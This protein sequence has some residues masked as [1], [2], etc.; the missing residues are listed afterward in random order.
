MSLTRSEIEVALRLSC[1]DI[2]A[3][4][5]AIVDRDFWKLLSAPPQEAG[6]D[7]RGDR[8]VG[9]TVD[10]STHTRT[11]NEW[12]TLART[13]LKIGTSPGSVTEEMANDRDR[14]R[15][16]L[17]AMIQL[18]DGK[19][20]CIKGETDRQCLNRCTKETLEQAHEAIKQS[21]YMR[22]LEQPQWVSVPREPICDDE[23]RIIY[24]ETIYGNQ[25]PEGI[26]DKSGY[27]FFFHPVSRYEG[28]DE[29]YASECK[30]LNALADYLLKAM[31]AAA[32]VRAGEEGK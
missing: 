1:K 21:S 31:L 12:L 10:G 19:L 7:E 32:P 23:L 18:H 16:A 26:R 27:L 5:A 9:I 30:Q 22:P 4:F 15:A 11:A 2:P 6:G 25:I 17:H 3:E 24:K 29:R 13:D 20:L 14:L 8:M 28:Q